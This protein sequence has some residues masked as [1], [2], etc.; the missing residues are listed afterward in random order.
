LPALFALPELQAQAATS[1]FGLGLPVDHYATL[2]T[3]VAAVTADQVKAV[4]QRAIVKEDFV[5]VLVGD[6]A[7]I[8]AG[9]AGKNLGEVV[10]VG[11]DGTPAK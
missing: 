9:L 1:L 3:A 11:K 10:F 6:K 5:V 8:E 2:N 4:A 7:A